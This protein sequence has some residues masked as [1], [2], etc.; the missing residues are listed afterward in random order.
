MPPPG[1]VESTISIPPPHIS[2]AMVK[3]DSSPATAKQPPP[4]LSADRQMTCTPAR[5]LSQVSAVTPHGS[6]GAPTF[7]PQPC[8]RAGPGSSEGLAIQAPSYLLPPSREEFNNHRLNIL[9]VSFLQ[10]QRTGLLEAKISQQSNF[11]LDLPSISEYLKLPMEA[12]R[13]AP[14]SSASNKEI[15]GGSSSDQLQPEEDDYVCHCGLLPVLHTIQAAGT[16]FGRQFFSCIQKEEQ[17]C[18]FFKWKKVIPKKVRKMFLGK[19]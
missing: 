1:D 13:S 6:G 3:A 5:P 19:F 12:C 14:F 4:G 8:V 15:P 2:S 7:L 9:E 10:S 17:Q 18:S 16:D 11:N